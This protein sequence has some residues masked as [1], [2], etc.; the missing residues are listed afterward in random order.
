MQELYKL[1]EK[2]VKELEDIGRSGDISKSSLSTIDTLAH[3]A[4]NL[5]KV[6]ESCESDEYGRSYDGYSRTED[7][8]R[9]DGSYRYDMAHGSYA[10]GRGK[11][12]ARDSMGRYSSA[13]MHDELRH[14]MEKAPDERTREE[15]KKL[16]DR[17]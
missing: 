5:T 6:I 1:K 11:N 13:G 10:R 7:F 15:L 8:V 14:L 9:P 4:K 2:L 12:A 17:I 3:A 16:M